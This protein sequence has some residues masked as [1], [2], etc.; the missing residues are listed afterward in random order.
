MI[1]LSRV[2]TDL[3]NVTG[4]YKSM[5]IFITASILLALLATT[6]FANIPFMA[7]AQ[8]AQE[9]ELR[10]VAAD[11][12]GEEIS[13]IWTSIRAAD[14]M[15]IGSGY[16]PLSFPG[17]SGDAYVVTVSDYDGMKF[18]QWETNSTDNPRTITLASDGTNA[19]E[20]TAQYDTGKSLRGVTPLTY[21]G[22]EDGLPDL[23]VE[24]MGGNETLHI[25][26]HIDPQPGNSTIEATYKVY[27]GNFENH[28]FDH[29]S[30]GSRDR[31][32]TLT[33]SEDTT[34]TA[35]Y[36]AG[37]SAIVIPEGAANPANPPY[38]P[39]EL[40]VKKGVTVVVSNVDEAPHSVTA[41]T[42][43]EDAAAG[44]AFETGLMFQGDYAHIETDRLDAGDYAYY[45]FVH[46][47]MTG[48]LTV[49]E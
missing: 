4:A 38:D 36:K 1:F 26:T 13:G 44:N 23:T 42:G 11:A 24:A 39:E 17:V 28:V 46:P 3:N 12:S 16:S 43:P 30:D 19:T 35:N 9:H 41:G 29:W 47:Y 10:I 18:K 34:V 15:Y 8:E 2:F 31:T 45:C 21:T 33:I 48:K 22:E 6:F 27:A 25:W 32:R 40:S 14:G 5:K 37:E 20:V 7:T 49:T